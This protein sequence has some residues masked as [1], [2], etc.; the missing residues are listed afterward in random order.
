MNWNGWV[1]S[2]RSAKQAAEMGMVDRVWAEGS[3]PSNKARIIAVHE[4][5][6]GYG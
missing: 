1:R 5:G 3:K 6:G 2:L 4:Y